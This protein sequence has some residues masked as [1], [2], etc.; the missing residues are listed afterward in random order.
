MELE[1]PLKVI[2]NGHHSDEDGFVSDL[3]P[4]NGPSASLSDQKQEEQINDITVGILG[5]GN[6]GK[7][8]AKRLNTAGIQYY[9]GSRSSWRYGDDGNANDRF[10]SYAEAADKADIVVFAVPFRVYG[11]IAT[12]LARILA[13]KIV[14]DIS[15]AETQSDECHAQR[16]ANLLPHS[17][18]VKAFNTISA[19]SM[20]N[21]IYGASRNVFVC[22][23]HVDSRRT[24]MQLVQDLGFMPVD[25][26]RLRA[27]QLLEKIPLQLFPGWR[28]ASWM[29]LGLL[30]IEL[31]YYYMREFLSEDPL[32]TVRNISVY[33]GNR[34]LCW[35]ALWLLSLVYLPGCLA[36]FL[37]LYRGTKYTR[38][39]SWLD[40]WMKSRK[41][42][43]LYAL[44]FAGMHA[45]LSCIALAG[46]YVKYMSN[47]VKIPGTDNYVY[48][49]FH[50]NAEVSL[51]FAV[52][53]MTFFIVLG[54]TSLPSV[55]QVMSWK[56]WDFVQSKLGYL[57]L[58]FAFFHVTIYAYEVYDPKYH[59]FW[60]YGIPPAVYFQPMLP[61]LV[62]IM[63]L[64][65][66]L[67]GI[68]GKLQ[69]IRAGWEK[70]ASKKADLKV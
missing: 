58:T 63:K 34:I 9:I 40:N 62:L 16:L 1:V 27:A 67:P 23:N 22:G 59:K 60:K 20:E 65:L 66:S 69:R 13:K 11:D 56:E 15:N 45:C 39:P 51:L 32:K 10:V 64:V 37:Q 38:F 30:V 44:A 5:F 25:R 26:G 24:V 19:W 4:I 17:H 54:I 52:L 55:N 29:T 48:F 68:A 2:T 61:G 49:R 33:H 14:V 50:W 8:L 70:N 28:V 6:Y 41:Q 35:M 18:V 57:T 21:D 43:G 42:L 7:A 46:E 36:G 3:Q 31:A 12:D 53:A 47:V